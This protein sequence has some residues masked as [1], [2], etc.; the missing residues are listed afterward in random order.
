MN[1]VNSKKDYIASFI[2]VIS[3]LISALLK[4]VFGILANSISIIGDGVN[5]FEDFLSIIINI[6]GIK[7]ANKAADDEHPFGHQR[8]KHITSLI[9][10]SLIL[11]TG[12]ILLFE[13]ITSLFETKKIEYSFITIYILII[14]IVIKLIQMLVYYFT[15]KQT[16]SLS[17]KNLS[18]DSLFDIIMTSTVLIGLLLSKYF[19]LHL[20]PYV[21]I[22]IGIAIF[23]SGIKMILESSQDLLGVK[24][25]SVTIKQVLE[26]IDQQPNILGHHDVIVHS[27]GEDK[28][29]L[30]V[31]L[32]LPADIPFITVHDIVDEIEIKIS[33]QFKVLI[34]IHPDPVDIKNPELTK[35]SNK[36]EQ[37]CQ[38]LNIDFHEIRI[39]PGEKPK[40]IFE[41]NLAYN[42]QDEKREI[43]DIFRNELKD[44][45]V[46]INFD[47]IYF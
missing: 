10:S 5:N 13:S 12:M 8:A 20:D 39:V 17:L 3:N 41:I 42:K 47:N 11:T 2:G 32:E 23:I 45:E 33:K 24:I 1:T 9:I 19:N 7:V 29:F 37:I 35:V 14:S 46:V 28:L 25:H 15:A 40:V 34:V 6:I 43:L 36:I 21:G 18:K 22:L 44:Y 38:K 30:S 16:K 27:Y 26:F 4:I 31:H